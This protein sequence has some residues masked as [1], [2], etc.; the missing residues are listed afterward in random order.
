MNAA[1]DDSDGS[2]LGEGPALSPLPWGCL[3]LGVA[4]LLLVFATFALAALLVVGTSSLLSPDH[5]G[6][7]C[8]PGPTTT[9]ADPS[10]SDTGDWHT[11]EWDTG[12][13]DD[14]GQRDP[15]GIAPITGV[16][17]ATA[18]KATE[19]V[20]AVTGQGFQIRSVMA[21]PPSPTM[22]G[23]GEHGMGRAI[24]VMVDSTADGDAVADY[25]WTHRRRLG[26]KWIVWNHRI[27]ST[28]LNRS[29]QWETYRGTPN[30]HTDHNHIFFADT[31]YTPPGT[32]NGADPTGSPVPPR[33][34][35]RCPTAPPSRRSSGKGSLGRA[36]EKGL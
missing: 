13:W 5:T 10:D 17:P 23:T 7:E 4:G 35:D 1:E 18:A 31:P 30:P 20:T 6:V 34:E 28:S 2:P 33:V 29:S 15:D 24:D 11:R 9:R 27:R 16:L 14:M 12:G 21:A 3:G 25:A 19:I 8:G 22:W 32:A 36:H 26:V